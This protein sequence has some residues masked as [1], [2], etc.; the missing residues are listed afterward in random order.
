MLCTFFQALSPC[1]GRSDSTLEG[2]RLMQPV[3]PSRVTVLGCPWNWES[4]PHFQ[5]EETVFRNRASA[6][7]IGCPAAL[8]TCSVECSSRGCQV[9]GQR[10]EVGFLSAGLLIA[11][12]VCCAL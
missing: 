6:D 5:A 8:N 12:Q 2:Q 4:G 1:E 9:L 11:L 3:F 7:E 10:S